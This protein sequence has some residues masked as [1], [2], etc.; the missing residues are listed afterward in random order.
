MEDNGSKISSDSI[1]WAYDI[2]IFPNYAS[3]LFIDAEEYVAM[4]NDI[5]DI[6]YMHKLLVSEKEKIDKIEA[7][8]H[9]LFEISSIDDYEVNDVLA[10]LDFVNRD[11]YLAG[12]NI[13]SYDNTVI[14]MLMADL[15][16]FKSIKDMNTK[17]YQLSKTI[18]ETD[19][20]ILK[21]D[22]VI[23]MYRQYNVRFKSIDVQRVAALDKVFKSLKQTLINL[24]WHSINEFNLPPIDLEKELKYYP[25]YKDTPNALK[26][27]KQWDRF[28]LK[29]HL[30]KLKIYNRND[31]LGV[32]ELF[33]FLQE[34]IGLR[35][36]L[37][38]RYGID[39]FSASDSRIADIF[40]SKYYSEYTGIPYDDYKDLRTYRTRMSIGKIIDPIIK[41]QTKELND[42]L[43]KLRQTVV[44]GTDEINYPVYFNGMIYDIKSGGIHSRDIPGTFIQ[45][46][47]DIA[48][49]K[50][51]DVKI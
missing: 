41:F 14:K 34:A 31:V 24:S 32:C 15:F 42:L 33:S 10:L 3:F 45:G 28:L 2:E 46:Q 51:G 29:E 1:V 16:K 4:Y 43:N 20:E 40:I 49:I 17:L 35:F 36:N 27:I 26:Y 21:R 30:D 9:I 39:V 11:I 6:K 38:I 12:F 37:N 23:R 22:Y 25:A 13:I 8:P 7:I 5:H 50:D 48:Y 18:V 47:K 44:N 19:P